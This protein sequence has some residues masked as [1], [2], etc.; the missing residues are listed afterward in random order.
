MTLPVFK[1]LPEKT[2]YSFKRTPQ[3]IRSRGEGGFGRTRKTSS[4]VNPI[5]VVS[6][7]FKLDSA[8]FNYWRAFFDT[9]IQ[10]GSLPFQMK[11][12]I[13]DYSLQLYDVTMSDGVYTSSNIGGNVNS[14]DFSVDVKMPTPNATSDA[15]L[16]ATFVGDF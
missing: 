12:I 6:C 13:A 9:T 3:I 10:A 15:A 14:L 4:M 8:Q 2:S 16:V 11:L 1:L 7:S 5:A